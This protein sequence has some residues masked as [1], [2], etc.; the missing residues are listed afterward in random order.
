V[1]DDERTAT[2]EEGNVAFIHAECA[3][4]PL[5]LTAGQVIVGDFVKKGFTY[6]DSGRT[7]HMW[8]EVTGLTDGGVRGTLA[9]DPVTDTGGELHFGDEV[10]ASYGE[11]TGQLPAVGGRF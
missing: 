11:I 8:M 2:T 1:T 3:P 4:P 9:N 5:G 6:K 10:E 7:E